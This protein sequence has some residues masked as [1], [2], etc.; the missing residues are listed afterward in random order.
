MAVPM[1]V[2]E[3][4]S[5]DALSATVTGWFTPLFTLH[6]GEDGFCLSVPGDH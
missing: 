6:F 3:L 1:L 4:C 5:R 2:K